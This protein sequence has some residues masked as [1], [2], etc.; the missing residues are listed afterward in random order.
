MKMESGSMLTTDIDPLSPVAKSGGT[1]FTRFF[2]IQ[3]LSVKEIPKS[4]KEAWSARFS[5]N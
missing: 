1:D 4:N 3:D 2:L 5:L